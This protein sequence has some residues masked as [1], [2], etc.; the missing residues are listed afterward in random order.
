MNAVRRESLRQLVVDDKRA[1]VEHARIAAKPVHE[2]EYVYVLEYGVDERQRLYD[3]GLFHRTLPGWVAVESARGSKLTENALGSAHLELARRFNVEFLDYSVVN[4]P[5]RTAGCGGPC[6]TR[7]R[8]ARDPR[9][10]VN[11]PLPS[12]SIST[13][14]PTPAILCPRRP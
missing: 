2:E 7:W 9:A 13:L 8:R 11:S 5:S 1:G 12:A 10:R 6:Q 4:R 14:S 3:L